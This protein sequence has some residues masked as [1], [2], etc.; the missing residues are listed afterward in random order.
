VLSE[1][2]KEEQIALKTNAIK[3]FAQQD[4]FNK[5]EF[6]ERVLRDPETAQVFDDFKNQYARDYDMEISDEFEISDNAVKKEKS[7][8]KSIVKLDKNFH[9][10]IHGGT[11]NITK[12][13]DPAKNLNFY[14][15]FF[16]N[17]S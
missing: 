7:G 15:L 10:Y 12:G 5:D 2:N 14:Q 4:S 3:Y 13:F 9:I 8:F 1:V 6:T 11:N 16:E 17:E